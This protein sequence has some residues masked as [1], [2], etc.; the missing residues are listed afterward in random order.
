MGW[1]NDIPN[2]FVVGGGG[3]SGRIE[4]RNASNVLIGYID[5]TGVWVVDPDGSYVRVYTEDPG[6]G[7]VIDFQPDSSVAGVTAPA[8]IG[9]GIDP[10]FGAGGIVITGPEINGVPAPQISFNDI[11]TFLDASGGVIFLTSLNGCTVNPGIGDF[12]VTD[13]NSLIVFQVQGS[14]GKTS[15]SDLVVEGWE[16]GDYLVGPWIS[17]T[18][19]WTSI[20]GV[21]PGGIG[22]GT[23]TGRYRRLGPGTVHAE[24]FLQGGTTT[25]WGSGI[26]AL[27]LPL[28]ATGASVNSSVGSAHALDSGVLEYA[29]AC[30][31]YTTSTVRIFFNTA[32]WGA[33]TPFTMGNNDNIRFSLLY[34]ATT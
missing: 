9:T 5:S 18:P 7:A 24:V 25:N 15:V 14:T 12:E 16:A 3:I 27:G 11:G 13:L 31:V 28:T 10:V 1:S 30:K 6:A 23:L 26:Y 20:T 29:G 32:S 34:E 4:I 22:N 2:P 17:Y 33:T 19:S 8:R 21:N